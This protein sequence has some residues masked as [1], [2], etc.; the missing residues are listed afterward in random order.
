MRIA[1]YTRKSVETD[2]GESIKTQ[3]NM[4]KEYLERQYKNCTYEIFEDE[5]FSGGTTKRPAFQRML[6]LVKMKQFDIIAVYKIDR[7][8]RNIVDFV[9]IFDEMENYNVKLISITEGFDPA[10][11]SGKMM[12]LLLASFAEMERMNIAQRVKDNMKE[13][14]K[15]GRWSGGTPPSGYASSSIVIDGKKN[16]FLKLV[17]ED[18]FFIKEIFQ[19]YSEGYSSYEINKHLKLKGLNFTEQGIIEI[20]KNPTYLKS[21]KESIKYL[22]S[23]G[24]TVYGEPNGC[25]FLPYNRRPRRKGVKSYNDKDKIVGVSKH[26]AIIDLDLWIGAHEKL[27]QKAVAPHPR[28]SSFTFLSGGIVK[29]KCKAT[30]EVCVGRKR[31]DGSRLYYFR[32]VNTCGNKSLR[33]DLGEEY[34]DNFI[35]E[36]ANKEILS[37]MSAKC[38]DNKTIDK[39]IR[40]INKQIEKNSTSINNLVDKLSLM[41]NEGAKIITEKIEQLSKTNTDLKEQL[42][43]LERE[44]LFRKRDEENIDV[45]Y[46]QMQA[47]VSSVDINEK[48]R[49]I[50]TFI[51]N[52]FWD[53]QDSSIKIKLLPL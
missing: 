26:E 49:L 22:D 52:I 4:C 41:T 8:A 28:E 14:A 27:K 17:E 33:V 24:Y 29:C 2:T 7:I 37:S 13:L 35:K 10:T 40:N 15:L 44:K 34:V 50:K 21:S 12:M 43:K 53:A 11:P 46:H 48:R 25:G 6:T 18:A 3:I 9:N 39:E 38:F 30:M 32:C 19:M 31:Q 20:L 5:G 47:Y 1:I 36:N 23:M 42:L 45:V 51:E 16:A